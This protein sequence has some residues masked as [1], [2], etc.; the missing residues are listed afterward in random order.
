MFTQVDRLLR[1]DGD[2]P[3]FTLAFSVSNHSPWE[4]PQGRIEPQGEPASVENTVR[5]ADWALGQF[6]ERA[7]KAPYWDNT[8]FLV[9]AD[10]DSR[11][12]GANLLPMRHFRIPALILGGG[13][14]ARQDTR[15]VSQIDMAP[16]LLSLM[17]LDTVH[18][19]LGADLTRRDPNRAIM[20]FGNNFGYLKGNTLAV[21]EPHKVAHTYLYKAAPLGKDDKY[22]ESPSE[23]CLIEK[24]LAH[25]LWPS[26]A[27]LSERYRLPAA[28]LSR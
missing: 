23:P 14:P 21:M 27:Y 12:D 13:V 15:I 2:K 4:Y 24:A 19:M 9:I 16:T 7:R 22:K 18:P 26:W 17:G 10:H 8:I 5:Y 11:A 1:A 28:P 25:A 20:Q 6:F 3:A